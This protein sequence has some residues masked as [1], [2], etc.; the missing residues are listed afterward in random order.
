[1]HPAVSSPFPDTTGRYAVCA[2]MKRP[3]AVS[4]FM[5]PRVEGIYFH[6]KRVLAPQLCMKVDTFLRADRC[7]CMK[8]DTFRAVFTDSCMKVDTLSDS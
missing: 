5:I 2:F 6:G 8:A 3:V 7:L 1:M 4:A